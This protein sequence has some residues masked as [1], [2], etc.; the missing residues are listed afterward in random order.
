MRL[1]ILDQSPIR[2]GSTATEALRETLQLAKLSDR[3]GYT[4]FWVS[5][6]HNTTVLAGSAPEILIAHLADHTR[7]IRLGSGGVMLPH[8][9]ALKVAET[10]RL[11]ET[12]FPGRI[13]LGLGRAPGGDRLTAS[14][15]NPMNQF[16]E[17]DFVQQLFDLQNWLNDQYEP[18]TIGEK[19]R[20]M[21]VASSVPQQW[22]LSS[23]GQSG[24]FAAHF[25]MGFSFAHFIN[26]EGGPQAVK[27]YRERFKPSINLQQ[28]EAM[29]AIFVFCSESEEKVQQQQAITDYRFIQFEKGRFEPVDYEEV[30]NVSYTPLEEQRIAAN[31]PRAIIGTPQVVKQKL[32]QLAADYD[33]NEIMMTN[34]TLD[35][36]DRMHS[37]EL[38]AQLFE[39]P[40][41]K[42]A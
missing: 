24:L 33:V 34:I 26:P 3:L 41:P 28:P 4:R 27:M 36:E 10:F 22:M 18:G 40:Q 12:L 8:Y 39:L 32:L 23:S 21:P 37:Y 20:A 30:K 7:H 25:G 17:Q 38:L 14:V 6:H 11:L 31:R 19:V 29:V 42:E 35:F 2:K 15:L 5:E 9:S 1:S 16:S 13:D